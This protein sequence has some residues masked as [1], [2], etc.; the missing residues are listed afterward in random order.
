MRAA[1]SPGDI[2]GGPNSSACNG[3]EENGLYVRNDSGALSLTV[4]N[5][6]FS[7]SVREDGI[8]LETFGTA[9]LTAL[10]KDG[11]FSALESDGIKAN[12]NA[13]ILN[14]TAQNNTFTGSSAG[15]ISDNAISFVSGGSATLRHTIAGNT[16]N[17][18][19]NS[20]MILQ[21]NDNSIMHGRVTG[22]TINGTTNGYGIDGT[23][24]AADNSRARLLIDG[25][26]ISG[27]RQGAILFNANNTG[28]LD[29]TITNNTMTSRPADPTAWENL[30]VSANGTS[31]VC[32]D[33]RGNTIARGGTNAGGMGFDADAIFLDDD[34]TTTL[35]LERGS[36]FS[37]DP[38]TVALDNNPAA[39]G[40]TISDTITLVD[41][42]TCQ[43]PGTT[44]TPPVSA[45][46]PAPATHAALTGVGATA[47][48]RQREEEDRLA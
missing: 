21:A 40:V 8:L 32:A 39:N 16:M 37:S 38:R 27:Q 25:N 18:S 1:G 30:N 23:L 9:T 6:D 35:R 43:D 4:D 7:T 34:P 5:T 13:S 11:A 28:Q 24:A 20:A 10:V 41:N 48:G 22:N 33:I 46:L 19:H 42:G 31:N 47:A 36:S 17:N 12:A 3:S 45:A 15:V 26:T 14:I 2:A 29:V 44:P